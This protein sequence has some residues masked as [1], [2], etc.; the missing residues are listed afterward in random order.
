MS[1]KM[2]NLYQFPDV[3]ICCGEPVPEGSMVCAVC[4]HGEIFPA[5]KKHVEKAKKRVIFKKRKEV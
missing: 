2:V 1:Q 4:E 3:C 5:A